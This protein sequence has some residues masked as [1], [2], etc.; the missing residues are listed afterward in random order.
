MGEGPLSSSRVRI[1]AGASRQ[2]ADAAATRALNRFGGQPLPLS[3]NPLNVLAK[4]VVQRTLECKRRRR[5]QVFYFHHHCCAERDGNTPACSVHT[6]VNATCFTASQRD[7]R[8]RAK[9][10]KHP[11]DAQIHHTQR[12]AEIAPSSIL[13]RGESHVC[14]FR[15][16]R[17]K[18]ARDPNTKRSY[19]NAMWHPALFARATEPPP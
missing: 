12:P 15:D 2:E 7:F 3:S 1:R 16:A 13:R 6:R 9:T 18:N 11:S 10:V 4:P 17:F 8:F 5:R 19:E 14:Q